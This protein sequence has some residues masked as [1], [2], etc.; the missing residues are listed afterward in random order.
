MLLQVHSKVLLGVRNEHAAKDYAATSSVIRMSFD[1]M[2]LELVAAVEAVLA[3]AAAVK[4]G[5]P[6][7]LVVMLLHVAFELLGSRELDWAVAV[8]PRAR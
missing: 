8:G 1:E 6:E 5:T 4:H 2:V 7:D 3:P